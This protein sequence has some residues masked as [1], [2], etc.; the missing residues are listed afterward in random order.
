MGR[1]SARAH[2]D[3]FPLFFAWIGETQPDVPVE[4]IQ[5]R[6]WNKL[7]AIV[8]RQLRSLGPWE[9][10]DLTDCRNNVFILMERKL[11]Q[12]MEIEVRA[13]RCSAEFFRS[14]GVD[15][16]ALHLL[17]AEPF[18]IVVLHPDIRPPGQLRAWLRDHD[19]DRVITVIQDLTCREEKRLPIPV[20][21]ELLKHEQNALLE[22]TPQAA[23]ELAYCA[24]VRAVHH[25]S[26][27]IR[28]G[29]VA[30]TA[31]RLVLEH[32]GAI[33]NASEVSSVEELVPERYPAA[34][35]QNH[36]AALLSAERAIRRLPA[37][38]RNQLIERYVDGLSWAEIA[39]KRKV[40]EVK[41]RQDD[42]RLMKELAKAFVPL[43]VEVGKQAVP[44]V[45]KWLKEMLPRVLE[46][47]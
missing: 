6:T 35:D 30:G 34:V 46:R 9:P 43:N 16:T 27:A 24:G 12:P 10:E 13:V 1:D 44:R 29:F 22:L 37:A 28:M 5:T 42:S 18:S 4:D 38:S 17:R 39:R 41:A 11:G 3:A 15:P 23:P 31:R 47:E 45:V 21:Y 14:L 40:T 36:D 19:D 20:A 7:T 26:F 32:R 8:I 25:E 2:I 33:G